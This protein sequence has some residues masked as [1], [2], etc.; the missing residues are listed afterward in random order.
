MLDM[1]RPTLTQIE[2]DKRPIKT[3]ELKM[4]SEIFDTSID[5][6]L[7]GKQ[8]ESLKVSKSQKEKFKHL[9]LYILSQVG[10]KYNVGKV[11]LYKLLYFSEFDF[12][13]LYGE[14]ISGYPFVKLP[15]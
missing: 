13:E 11:V 15:M 14:Y 9:I 7:S 6:L 8:A 10:A 12:Y 5:F 2:T 3:H 4:I 1:S